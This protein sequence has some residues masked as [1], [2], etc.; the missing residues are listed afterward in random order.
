MKNIEAYANDLLEDY[1]NPTN[2]ALDIALKKYLPSLA[3][4]L[5]LLSSGYAQAFFILLAPS[6]IAND[7]TQAR[8]ENEEINKLLRSKLDNFLLPNWPQKYDKV[9]YDSYLRIKGSP[10]PKP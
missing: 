5:G 2:I 9:F 7:F 3:A 4:F 1:T 8:L 6:P 10:L